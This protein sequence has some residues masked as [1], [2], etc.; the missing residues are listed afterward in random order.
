[1]QQTPS[2]PDPQSVIEAHDICKRF[3]HV[4]AL[5][6]ASLKIRKGEIQAL[7]GDNG[8][9]KSTLTKVLCGALRPDSGT[10]RFWGESTTVQSI[11]HAHELGVETVYQDLALAPDLSVAANLFLGREVIR[12]GWSRWLGVLERRGMLRRARSALSDLGVEL[13]YLDL[14]LRNLSGGQ[15]QAVAVARAL[16]WARTAI[17]MD[18]PTAALGHRQ[19]EVVYQAIRRAARKG[20]AVV[21]IS[22]DIP[23]MVRFSDRVAI[24]RH[25]AVIADRPSAGLGVREVIDLML[26]G[27]AEIPS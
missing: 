5:R 13:P 7:V 27:N 22:H 2:R 18:E 15:R 19:T 6:N 24:M 14:P 12:R 26:E 4:E 16:T 8:A 25:G 17:L 20:L 10:L 9:G 1:M 21:V 11:R 3:G 23:R